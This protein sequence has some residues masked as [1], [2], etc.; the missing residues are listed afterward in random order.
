M[1]KAAG[2]I[3]PTAS[4]YSLIR[5]FF[6][7]CLGLS[8]AM[9][10]ACAISDGAP[11]M[12]APVSLVCPPHTIPDVSRLCAAIEV[13]LRDAGYKLQDKAPIRLL[14]EAD[15]PKPQRLTARLI[16]QQNGMR[17]AGEQGEL[18]VMDRADIPKNRIDSFARTLVA[19]A[20]LPPVQN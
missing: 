15:A 8:G 20:P 19:R 6:M 13:A 9:V 2:G 17:H 11:A 10:A 1:K 7:R 3:L 4:E 12:A 18:T 5:V 16:V 14:L